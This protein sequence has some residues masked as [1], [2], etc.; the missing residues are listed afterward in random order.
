M[1]T[2]CICPI[3]RTL[4]IFELNICMFTLLC[5]PNLP[6]VSRNI[7]IKITAHVET[8]LI[9]VYQLSICTCKVNELVNT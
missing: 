4:G 8:R 6:L 2:V 5:Y 7:F 1:H 3:E 9:S